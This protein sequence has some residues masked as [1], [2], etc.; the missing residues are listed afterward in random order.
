ME[1]DPFEALV[2]KTEDR[3]TMV[4]QGTPQ[5]VKLSGLEEWVVEDL[6][7]DGEGFDLIDSEES[8]HNLN[9]RL[10]E[11]RDAKDTFWIMVARHLEQDF[12]YVIYVHTPT[13]L[14]DDYDTTFFFW[15]TNIYG[16]EK[17]S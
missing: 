11:S 1:N 6:E 17:R 3:V 8:F 14:L 13:A 16:L 10:Y 15:F 12:S 9:Y 5:S 2:G 4:I 7:I